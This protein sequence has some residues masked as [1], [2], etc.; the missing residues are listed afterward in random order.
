MQPS[1]KESESAEWHAMPAKLQHLYDKQRPGAAKGSPVRYD[2]RGAVLLPSK[3][4]LG[5]VQKTAKDRDR[6]HTKLEQEREHRSKL[7][8]KTSTPDLNHVELPTYRPAEPLD[9]K[10]AA[11]AGPA[12]LARWDPAFPGHHTL[13][14]AQNDSAHPTPSAPLLHPCCWHAVHGALRLRE[15]AKFNR[16]GFDRL[17]EPMQHDRTWAK[18]RVRLAGA[19]QCLCPRLASSCSGCACVALA[20]ME[21][22]GIVQPRVQAFVRAAG[23]TRLDLFKLRVFFDMLDR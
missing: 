20:G 3:E 18:R 12:K 17:R 13:S 8:A 22:L 16:R 7:E 15:G 10:R 1:E 6:Y 4:R 5:I 14:H 11:A 23:L 2:Q 21:E 19:M 9:T